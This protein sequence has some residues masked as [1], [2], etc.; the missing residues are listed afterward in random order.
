VN[1]RT[2]DITVNREHSAIHI[3]QRHGEIRRHNCLAF[4]DACT[5]DDQYALALPRPGKDNRG[6]HGAKAIG[7]VRKV[8]TGSNRL[9]I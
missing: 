7:D 6:K 8:S 9:A 3:R 5:D 1:S 2:S 4:T